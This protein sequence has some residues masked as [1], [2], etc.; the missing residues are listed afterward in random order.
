MLLLQEPQ[1]QQL[2]E[3]KHPEDEMATVEEEG[4]LL[5][6]QLHHDCGFVIDVNLV[7]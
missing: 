2:L 6:R 7:F 1:L 3:T 5:K 4:E